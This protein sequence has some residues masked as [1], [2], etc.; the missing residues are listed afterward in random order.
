[1]PLCFAKSKG[2]GYVCERCLGHYDA[3][4][5]PFS[6]PAQREVEY[7]RRDTDHEVMAAVWSALTTTEGAYWLVDALREA[8]P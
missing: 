6:S 4:C 3:G 8:L 7:A 5:N 1:L 2:V